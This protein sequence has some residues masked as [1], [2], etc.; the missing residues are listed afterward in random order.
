MKSRDIDWL[1]PML[2]IVGLQFLLWLWLAVSGL[3]P[4]PLFGLSG[5]IAYTGLAAVAVVRYLWLLFAMAKSG[6]AKPISRS[7]AMLKQNAGRLMIAIVAV[8]VISIQSASFNAIKTAIPRVNPFWLDPYLA[9]I[10]ATLFGE[11]PWK[12]AHNAF[13]FAVPAFDAAYA[14]WLILQPIAFFGL[15][16]L[17]PSP[18]KSR[19]IVSLLLSWLILGIGAAFLFSS[20]GPIFYD[21]L[22]GGGTFAGLDQVD[23]PNALRASEYL[24]ASYTSGALV[25]GA[26][27]SAMPSLHVGLAL[28]LALVLRKSF[29]APLAWA[30]LPVIWIGSVLLGWHYF[31]DGLL[32][33]IGVAII[34]RATPVL[35]R[36]FE[37]AFARPLPQNLLTKLARRRHLLSSDI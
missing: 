32:G 13:G 8:Q 21:R 14:A 1:V 4:T 19:A 37:A 31:T 17:K 27:I 12:L 6:E 29:L 26:G 2:L 36:R 11:Q 5:L 9:H 28:W 35:L 25:I 18:L 7:I 10:D 34:W 33:L 15:L 30:Y 3:A 16:T 22:F 23:A 20:A 24:W